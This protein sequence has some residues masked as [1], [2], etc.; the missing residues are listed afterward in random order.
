MKDIFKLNL[1]LFAEPNTQTTLLVDLKPEIKTFYEDSLLDNAEPYLVH[2]QFADKY[3]IPRNGGKTIE[4]RR[5][6]PLGKALT[7]LTEGVTP[8]GNKLSV[9]TLEATVAQYGDYIT[10]SDMLEMTAIDPVI[11]QANKLLGSQA[12]RTLDTITREVLHSCT[13]LMYAPKEGGA[14]VNDISELDGTCSLT[15]PLIFKAV[16]KLRTM[17]ATPVDDMFVAVVHPNVACDL[18][19]SD[20]W[21]EAHKYAKPENIYKGEIGQLGGV[22]FVQ[23][24]EAKIYEDKGSD[25]SSVYGTIITGANAYGTTDIEGGGLEFIVKQR[26]SSGTADP[27]NQRSTVGWKATKTAEILTDTNMVIIRHTAKTGSKASAN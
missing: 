10:V 22:R 26:G 23:T 15:V 7:Q 13:N 6:S 16:A 5:F 21:I 17:N 9:E 14:E 19:L 3:P 8:N 12:G 1:Q 24:T 2:D 11:A 27:L 25:G 4:F 20:G 18:M